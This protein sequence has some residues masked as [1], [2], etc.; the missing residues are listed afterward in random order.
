MHKSVLQLYIDFRDE[1]LQPMSDKKLKILE[2]GSRLESGRNLLRD[3]TVNDNWEF[4]GL[5][6]NAGRNVDIVSEDPYKYPFEDNTFDVVLSS[7]TAE[8]VQDMHRWIKE[9]ARISKGL[10]WIMVP[11]TFREHGKFDYW[12]IMPRGMRYLMA[13]IGGLDVIVV[14][15]N[16]HNIEDTFG[17]AKKI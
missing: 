12:R 5:D 6:I 11:N 17:I 3:V 2:I 15:M 13:D 8:H 16:K 7:N 9:V 1:Y 4:I 14:G 10:V